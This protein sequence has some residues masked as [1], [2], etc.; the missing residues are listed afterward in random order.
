MLALY[1]GC[2]TTLSGCRASCYSMFDCGRYGFSNGTCVFDNIT[3]PTCAYAV[4]RQPIAWNAIDRVDGCHHSVCI[5]NSSAT[6]IGDDAGKQVTI[7]LHN[8]TSLH[9]SRS[10]P[11]TLTGNGEGVVVDG[12][13]CEIDLEGTGVITVRTP[14]RF[15]ISAPG[16]T[17]RVLGPAGK[18]MSVTASVVSDVL[19]LANVDGDVDVRVRRLMI[20]EARG[21]RF[22]PS[23]V[24]SSMVNVTSL[25]SLF[26]P[27]VI[28]SYLGEKSPASPDPVLISTLMTVTTVVSIVSWTT[29]GVL[30][31]DYFFFD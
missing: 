15:R 25:M 2:A 1:L 29:A 6:F 10:S 17:V 21:V 18:P 11:F 24:W 8:A 19:L 26:S 9:V 12:G 3:R 31:F 16:A 14:S 7:I 13:D 20:Q 23:G 22:R 27:D 4:Q 28:T 30:G 5:V